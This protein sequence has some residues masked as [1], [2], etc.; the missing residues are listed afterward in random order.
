MAV[1]GVVE[2][3]FEEMAFAA[4]PDGS[5]FRLWRGCQVEEIF[6]DATLQH[7]PVVAISPTS[8]NVFSKH[9]P[10]EHDVEIKE[11]L[12]DQIRNP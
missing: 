6:S 8:A 10:E 12:D 9:A 7:G 4:R 11:A 3:G 2:T 5:A 1:E